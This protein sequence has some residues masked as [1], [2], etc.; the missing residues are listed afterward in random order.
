MAALDKA[1]RYLRLYPQGLAGE[2]EH[3]PQITERTDDLEI[4]RRILFV[5]ERFKRQQAKALPRPT[6]RN[7][8]VA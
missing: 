4:A 6:T 7:R 3:P 1:M 2:E 8:E 5:A